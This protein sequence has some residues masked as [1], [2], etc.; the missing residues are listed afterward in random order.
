MECRSSPVFISPHIYINATEM[1]E[2]LKRGSVGI[3]V[4]YWEND[5]APSLLEESVRRTSLKLS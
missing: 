3:Y 2:L 4:T 1:M 5:S